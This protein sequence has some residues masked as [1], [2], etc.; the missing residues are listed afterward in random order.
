MRS[1]RGAFIVAVLV[2]GL[3]ATGCRTSGDHRFYDYQDLGGV[4]RCAFGTS[5]VG[6][7]QDVDANGNIPFGS[8]TKVRRD[9]FCANDQTSLEGWNQIS[10]RSTLMYWRAATGQ[11][12]MCAIV[13]HQ[14]TTTGPAIQANGA[15]QCGS[16][17]YQV[18]S[19][20]HAWTPFVRAGLFDATPTVYVSP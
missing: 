2:V 6:E 9:L 14:I 3:S 11:Y 8:T 10:A 16:T 13:L 5:W 7:T 12:E 19:E 17:Y 1:R 15:H 4:Y 18:R 20:H